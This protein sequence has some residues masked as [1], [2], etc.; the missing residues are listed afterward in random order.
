MFS[1]IL[2]ICTHAFCTIFCIGVCASCSICNV[3]AIHASLFLR[4]HVFGH[5]SS[6]LCRSCG[7]GICQI[8]FLIPAKLEGL[9]ILLKPCSISCAQSFMSAQLFGHILF[10]MAPRLIEQLCSSE[11]S[12]A[13]HSD[14]LTDLHL[15]M[16]HVA[17]WQAKFSALR[18]PGL[19]TNPMMSTRACTFDATSNQRQHAPPHPA[20]CPP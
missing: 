18:P 14:H 17:K 7:Q 13:F 2:E 4:D 15:H 16:D 10:Q 12:F 11:L 5:L 3:M 19:G 8:H 6:M 1:F 20:L 9:H